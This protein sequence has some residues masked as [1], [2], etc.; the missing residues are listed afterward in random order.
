MAT[1]W[2]DV[3]KNLVIKDFWVL[4]FINYVLNLFHEKN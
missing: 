4:R 3:S 1:G 2:G